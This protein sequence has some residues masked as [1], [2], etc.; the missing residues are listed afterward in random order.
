MP[1][2]LSFCS[3]LLCLL[4]ELCCRGHRG[5]R[6]A[7]RS[8]RSSRPTAC[9]RPT[10]IHMRLCCRIV[11]NSWGVFWVSWQGRFCPQEVVCLVCPRPACRALLHT[12][13]RTPVP[14]V[15]HRV[16]SMSLGSTPHSFFCFSSSRRIPLLSF[17][18]RGAQGELGFFKIERGVNALRM[19]EGDC[20]WVHAHLLVACSFGPKSVQ[21]QRNLRHRPCTPGAAPAPPAGPR[22]ALRRSPGSQSSLLLQQSSIACSR[23]RTPPTPPPTP[24]HTTPPPPPCHC[25]YAVPTWQDEQDVRSG[26]KVREGPAHHSPPFLPLY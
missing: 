9:S 3:L 20:W 4:H 17:R 2:R 1:L 11:R 5:A 10:C 21:P 24:T 14:A 25:R 18:P 16:P 22:T 6:G 15:L 13:L 8:A 26:K 12:C 23:L 7:A 19:E